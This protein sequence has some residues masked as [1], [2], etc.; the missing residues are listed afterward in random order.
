MHSKSV[1]IST[2]LSAMLAMPS[3]A[4]AA[5]DSLFQSLGGKEGIQ[6][7]V[8]RLIPKLLE[9]ARIKDSFREA[10]MDNLKV[11]L[12]E[13][14]C[15][16]SGGPCTYTGKDMKL[17]HDGLNI[18]QAQFNALV[19]VLQVAMDESGIAGSTQNRLLARL[20]PMFSQVVTK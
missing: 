14:F 5:D 10:D 8:G 12:A 6:T 2:L 16:V 13:Q 15:Q 9:D 17:I 3:A 19:E 11:K 18:T 20:A 1:L 4:Q 7:V